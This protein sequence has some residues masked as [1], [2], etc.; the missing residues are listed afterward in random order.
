MNFLSNLVPIGRTTTSSLS[1]HSQVEVALGLPR[2]ALLAKALAQ[3][4]RGANATDWLRMDLPPP[5][6]LRIRNLV[7]RGAPRPV[8]KTT[9]VK[10][11]RVVQCESA[12]EHEAAL[13]LDVS[14]AVH[15]YAEQPARIHYRDQHTWRSHIPDFVA[16]V[17]D[18]ISF[19]EIKFERDVDGEVRHRTALMQERLAALDAGYCLMTERHVRQGNHVQNAQRVLRRARHTITEVQRLATLE[20]LR[21]V[22][23]VPL[24][25][26]G[27]CVADSHDAVGIAQ[28]IMSGHAATDGH[29]PLSDRSC[30]WLS[31]SGHATGS[32]A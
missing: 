4:Q 9:S 5:G 16:F 3:T 2:Q 31:E 24:A 32:A 28:L 22:Q 15:A 1:H 19:I 29:G 17:A 11:N 12:L 13:L 21:G 7:H 25:A 18:R 6:E 27:W 14:P 26:F 30:V 8:F 23:R 20:K 10:L